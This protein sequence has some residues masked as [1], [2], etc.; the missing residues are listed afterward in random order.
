MAKFPEDLARSIQAGDC[1]LWVGAGFGSLAGRPSWEALLTRL[2][3]Q[4]PEEARESL[5]ELLE[6]GRLR[7]V[8]TYVHRHLGDEPLARLLAEVS[9][10]KVELGAS[11]ARLRDVPWRACFATTYHDVA[12]RV[13]TEDGGSPPA[14]VTHNTVHYLS[15]REQKD[16]FIL[17]TPPTGR[18][19]RTDSVLFDFVEEV[20]RSRTILFLGF[21]PDDPDLTQI[22]A[23]FERV[24]R[25]N[26]HFAALPMVTEPEA[27]EWLDRWN[28]EV[29]HTKADDKLGDVIGDVIASTTDVAV[30]P[31]DVDGA[32]AVLD[33]TRAVRGVELRADLARDAGLTLEPG[34]VEH[35]IGA[36]PGQS[37]A[38]VDSPTLLR[39]G[40]VLLAHRRIEKAR[41]CF[42][43]V[44][45]SGAEGELLH[46]ARFNLALT[47]LTE[48][49]RAAAFDGLASLSDRSLALIPPRFELVEV[50]GHE[51]AQT[52]LVCRDRES[53]D[54]VA[55]AVSTLGRPV[56][57]DEQSA[58]TDEVQKLTGVDHPAVCKVRGGFADGRLFG[59][60]YDHQPGFI[61][62]DTFD[63]DELMS[64]KRATELLLPLA[65]G[66]RA[67]H[68]AGVL[69]RNIN[70]FTVLVG[71]E[72]PMLRGFGFP[73]VIGFMRPSVRN[74]NRGFLA[75]EVL[76][77][78]EASPAS[79]T[80]ALAA[81]LYRC[82]VGEAP[83]GSVPPP[84]GVRDLDP[85]LDELLQVALH[86]NP[87]KRITLSE[88]R[89]KLD[90]IVSTPELGE[91]QRLVGTEAEPGKEEVVD[92]ARAKNQGPQKITAPEDPDDLEA[93][94]WILERKPMHAQALKNLDRIEAEARGASRWDRVV[95]VLGIRVKLAQ[96]QQDRVAYL[97]EMVELF[98]TKLGAP[99][100]AFESMQALVEE[101]DAAE[102]VDLIDELNRLA[103]VTGQ[104]A[105]M[106]DTLV[107]VAR[108]A[109]DAEDRARLQTEL[110]DVF[111]LRLG[112]DDQALVAYE[113][114][115]ELQ[116]TAERQERAVGLYRKRGADVELAGALVS[117]ADLQ[118]GPE[119][120]ESLLQ[121][122]K[123]LRE[124]LDDDEGAAGCVDIVLAEEAEHPEA[125]AMAESLARQQ[126]NYDRL[127]EILTARAEASVDP[128]EAAEL[129]RE[130]VAIAKEHRDD[131]DATIAQLTELTQA[132]RNDKKAATELI[133]ILRK[134]V[135]DEPAHRMT[136]I[137]TLGILVDL[138]DTAEEKASLL[139]ETA[140]HLDQLPDGRDRAIDCR[141]RVLEY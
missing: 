128:A 25:G 8:L 6:Q 119:R 47:A 83:R 43:Q 17:K 30:R 68:D 80:Y 86:P 48:G 82:L 26:R 79:D 133:E 99:R 121:A 102:Q 1:V 113:K 35:L 15:L 105:P 3:P 81:L 127:Y 137:D 61:L 78:E 140:G 117:L 42:Q 97:R 93:W 7:T 58:F 63:D 84:S 107:V 136:L 18:S 11:A 72:T 14:V 70:P 33:L 75:P 57:I 51:G 115:L 125:L 74:E 114:A 29:I 13:F 64:L 108:R 85:R 120:H 27:E 116:P 23:L 46:L 110:G 56:G 39:A 124:A 132:D 34:W 92:L 52:T 87:K 95:E 36:L 112:A 41:S 9:E 100:N 69:H 118:T 20:V 22:L 96:V 21:E 131:S 16:F 66:L 54:S 88:L 98:E 130:A 141:E 59:V 62:A 106:A 77:G 45:S 103:E 76:A 28:I 139:L 37:L 109:K 60:L 53:K 49:D 94:A 67:C 19:M 5:T 40:S 138:V 89:E 126:E 38:G 55:I 104:W 134:K 65:D 24:G 123:V 73:P 135:G 50:L 12:E 32:L 4:C 10:D 101:V 2:V 122:A 31:S 91:A 90:H 71:S 111:S 129:R 44:I